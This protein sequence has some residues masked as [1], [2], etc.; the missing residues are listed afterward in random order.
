MTT[1]RRGRVPIRTVRAFLLPLLLAAAPAPDR[2]AVVLGEI[3]FQLYREY[4]G[5]L[6]APVGPKFSFWN[7]GA[8]EG[9]AQEP[10][11][12]YLISVPLRS[13]TGN[14][15]S[16]DRPVVLTVRTAAGK[17]LATRTLRYALVPYQGQTYATLWLYDS[18]CA[19]RIAITA[20]FAG[21]VKRAGFSLDCGEYFLFIGG[22]A[23][24]RSVYSSAATRTARPAR[25]GTQSPPPPPPRPPARGCRPDRRAIPPRRRS[26]G[27]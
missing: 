22:A 16:V 1:A 21:Q 4:S 5:T 14:A 27:A 3:R 17:V 20:T 2:P 11:S 23:R 6:S 24:Y 12:N 7:T 19:G 26:A 18:P 15:E 13:T 8:G 9:D 10:A 25:P